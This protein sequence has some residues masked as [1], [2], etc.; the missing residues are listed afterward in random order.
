MSNE[1]NNDNGQANSSILF[2]LFFIAT[3]FG[4]WYLA[5]ALNTSTMACNDTIKF[6]KEEGCELNNG[7]D[8]A[9]L[10]CNDTTISQ[11]VLNK[12][13]ENFDGASS[14]KN[15]DIGMTVLFF[16]FAVGTCVYPLYLRSTAKNNHL[17]IVD[18]EN[19]PL[20][21]EAKEAKEVEEVNQSDAAKNLGISIFNVG[22]ETLLSSED[23]KTIE[24]K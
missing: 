11:S 23:T 8:Q 7:C 20:E 15:I 2:G 3:V 18:I 1:N 5:E 12:M 17:R 4:I 19:Q 13:K 22:N 14:Q 24:P 9:S 16:L 10:K 6:A 21:L